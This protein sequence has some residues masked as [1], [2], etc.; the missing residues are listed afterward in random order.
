[1]RLRSAVT[2]AAGL[3]VASGAA[4]AAVALVSGDIRFFPP[5]LA[6]VA[7]LAVC[8]GLPAYLAARAARRDTPLVAAGLGFL[9]G[10]AIPLF[11]ILAGT[12]DQASIGDSATVINGRYTFAGWMHNLGFV[13]GFGLLGVGGALVFWFTVRR[14]A[15][16]EEQAE[17]TSPPSLLRTALLS[18]AAAGLVATALIIPHATADRSCHNPLRGGGTSIGQTAGFELRVGVDQWPSVAAEVERFRRSGVWSER[19]DLRTDKEFPWLQISLCKEAGTDIFVGGLAD[20]HEVSFG[21]YQPQG[22]NSWRR[23][24]RSLYDRISARWPG[25]VTFKHDQGR[26]SGTPEWATEGKPR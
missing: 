19:R 23:D 12:P 3:T 7:V 1:M 24:F 15:P 16:S 11:L 6:V 20:F 5:T 10:A 22:G 25:Q 14:A 21:V 13:G 26:E 2:I 9:V 4:A 18:V 8:L 17:E